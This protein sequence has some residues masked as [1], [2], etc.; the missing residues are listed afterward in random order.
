[1]TLFAVHIPEGDGAGTEGKMAYAAGLQAAFDFLVVFAGL[2]Q[3]RQIALNIRHK[4][5]HAQ[6]GKALGQHLQ[7]DRFAR[8]RGPGDEAVAVGQGGQHAY[9]PLRRSAHPDIAVEKHVLCLLCID[10]RARFFVSL[11]P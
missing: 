1:M 4:N 2:A 5:G 3:A 10:R 7:R 9:R 11:A 6:L 8:A